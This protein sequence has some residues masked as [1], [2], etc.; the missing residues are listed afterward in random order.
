MKKSYWVGRLA[1]AGLALVGQ[2]HAATMPI[3]FSGTGVSG[4]LVI[5]FGPDTDA[6]YPQRF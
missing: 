5:T 6:K 2:A 3:Y 1:L 4:S